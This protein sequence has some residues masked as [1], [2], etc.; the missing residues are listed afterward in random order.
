[1]AAGIRARLTA[2]GPD[3]KDHFV[4]TRTQRS[5]IAVGALLAGV[6]GVALTVPVGAAPAAPHPAATSGTGQVANV[7]TQAKI[8]PPNWAKPVHLKRACR[9]H[10]NYPRPGVP[11]RTWPRAADAGVKIRYNIN[12]TWAL[13]SDDIRA[14]H[15][16]KINPHYGFIKRSCLDA[17]L[18]LSP[19]TGVGGHGTTRRVHFNPVANGRRVAMLHVTGNPT[20]RDRPGAFAIGNLRAKYH[21]TFVIGTVHCVVSN[22]HPWVHGYAPAARRWGYVEATHLPGCHIKA[23]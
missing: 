13:V 14:H 17:Q 3:G 23:G 16:P 19:L 9:L 20:L 15:K 10:E 1:M 7:S 8:Y 22:Q 18:P 2:P 12:G 5:G 21:D 11:D 6:A 4:L